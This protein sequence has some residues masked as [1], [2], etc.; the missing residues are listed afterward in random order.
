MYICNLSNPNQ[1]F[2]SLLLPAFLSSYSK[3]SFAF[4]SANFFCSLLPSQTFASKQEHINLF[5]LS[6]SLPHATK[7]Y[8]HSPISILEAHFEFRSSKMAHCTLT[9]Y[10]NQMPAST[11]A[12]R[13]T[14]WAPTSAKWYASQS[15]V[16]HLYHDTC[17]LYA[18]HFRTVQSDSCLPSLRG[19]KERIEKV[20]AIKK[21]EW[22]L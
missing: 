11:C 3:K 17:I 9:T 4:A 7:I 1:L 5:S 12:A 13:Q 22:P 14:A 15:T 6:L 18:K 21:I 8:P 20:Q 16:R 10:R 19:G 2:L